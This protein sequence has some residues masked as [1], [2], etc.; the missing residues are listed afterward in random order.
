MQRAKNVITAIPSKGDDDVDYGTGESTDFFGNDNASEE[1]MNIG[2]EKIHNVI[3]STTDEEITQVK[4]DIADRLDAKLPEATML[5]IKRQ[6]RKNTDLATKGQK[7]TSSKREKAS[8]IVLFSQG[9]SRSE[10][11]QKVLN[12]QVS[13][14]MV[15]TIVFIK[16]LVLDIIDLIHLAAEKLESKS[17]SK[18]PDVTALEKEIR[19]K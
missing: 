14:V 16:P 6:L 7:E 8:S 12:I 19:E 18:M 11:E 10:G 13:K 2:G 9:E 4:K 17:N 5:D 3:Q 15:P 1:I